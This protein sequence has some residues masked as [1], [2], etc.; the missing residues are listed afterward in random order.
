MCSR[1]RTCQKKRSTWQT[2]WNTH[3]T[4]K[5]S[6]Q[7]LKF[8]SYFGMEYARPWNMGK[9]LLDIY[10]YR[11]QQHPHVSSAAVNPHLP[12]GG[13]FVGCGLGCECSP[14][15]LGPRTRSPK[16][17]APTPAKIK[18][19]IGLFITWSTN[20]YWNSSNQWMFNKYISGWWLTYPSEKWWSSSVGMMTFPNWMEKSNS[21]SKPPTRYNGIEWDIL[22]Q[23]S[24]SYPN[25]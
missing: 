16:T 12:G 8:P 19:I 5:G 4:W 1:Q 11:Y 18:G 7:F 6:S 23:Y 13:F 15:A 22:S 25:S 2:V 17:R 14:A 20:W 9:K 21:C 3:F 10:H 24:H